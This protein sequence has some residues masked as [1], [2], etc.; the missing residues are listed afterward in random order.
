MFS[1]T[2]PLKPIEPGYHLRILTNAQLADFKA[3][4]LEILAE[5]GVH[6]PSEK[7]LN[8]YAEHGA[9]VDFDN[10]I[11]KLPPDLV[12]AAMS[13]A[14]RHYTMG[15]RRPE[16][17]LTL[18]GKHFYCATDGCGTEVID[19]ATRERRTSVKDDVAQMARVAD[20]L[21]SIGFYWPMVS[22]QD[23]PALAPLHELDA[24]LNNTVKHVQTETVMDEFMARYAVEMAT[25]IAGDEATRRQR[26]PLSSLVCTIAPLSQDKGGMES[27]LVFAEAG[28]PVGF[29]SMAN[30]GST[31]PATIPGTL[32]AADAEIVAAL[33]LI[34]LAY[35]GAPTYHSMMPGVMH[36]RTGGYLATPWEGG[37]SYAIGVEL[38]HMWGVPSLAGVFGTDGQVP[39]WQSA[40]ESAANLL[41]CALVGA[42]TGA[43][44]G[45]VESCTLLYPEAVV[46]D[47]DIYHQ[48]RHL[49]RGIDTS[50]EALALE[51][52]QTVGPRGHFLKEKHTRANL[53][54]L[55]FSDLTAQPDPTGGFRDPVEVA[56]EKADWILA[57]HQPEPLSDPQKK[58]LARILEA[59]AR[60]LGAE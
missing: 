37:L 53:R 9:Q 10:E 19:F 29:M 15:A 34:Q 21:T 11:V 45:L 55:E 17:D 60:E 36:P 18:D 48:V 22:A 38:A 51:V 27:A 31:G 49:A 2:P 24:S 14:P 41:L 28:L 44:L 4:S 35:P 12:L 59:A 47:T 20:Y 1:E 5:V 32:A 25:V 52:I 57:N 50:R 39:G 6:C 42:D 40:A 56:R 46:L 30:V 16:L 8:I 43:G 13:H 58:E 7:A 3:A 54:Q 26:P 33:V 23:F